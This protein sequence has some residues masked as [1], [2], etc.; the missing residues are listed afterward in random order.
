MI[1]KDPVM[2][3]F[4][5]G[6]HAS[7]FGGNPLAASAV[8]ATL[9][10]IVYEGILKNCEDVGRYLHERLLSLQKTYPFIT[11][12][13]GIGLIWGIELSINGDEVLKD[14][15]KEGVMINCTKG[16]ILRLLPP[17]IIRKEEV[18]IFMEIADR[19]F[20]KWLKKN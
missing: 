20:E 15:M 14:F 10:V 16:N 1:A 7:T 19:I 8:V 11:D 18:D 13:R 17:L 2:E 9:N 5:P 6:T 12:V 4:V 3:A